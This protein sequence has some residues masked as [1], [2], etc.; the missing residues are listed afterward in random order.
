MRQSTL[1]H[2]VLGNLTHVTGTELEDLC[3]NGIFFHQG[4]L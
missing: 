1:E 2:T 3:C 4:F